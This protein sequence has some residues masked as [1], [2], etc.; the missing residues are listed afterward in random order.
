MRLGCM[1]DQAAILVGPVRDMAGMEIPAPR[2]IVYLELAEITSDGRLRGAWLDH[3]DVADR[4]G[5]DLC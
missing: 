4:R 1:A 3:R 5:A 2:G